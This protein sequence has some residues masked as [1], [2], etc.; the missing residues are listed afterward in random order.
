[1]IATSPNGTAARV[2]YID[3]LTDDGTRPLEEWV[4]L[5]PIGHGTSDADG[6]DEDL[7][8]ELQGGE[9]D[10][11][12]LMRHGL[13][14]RL[15]P[16]FE[17]KYRLRPLP[18][19][20]PV[21]ADLEPGTLVEVR[22]NDG[23]WQAEIIRAD[24]HRYLCRFPGENDQDRVPRRDMRTALCWRLGNTQSAGAAPADNGI[25]RAHIFDRM[26]Q[27]YLA[28]TG[29][30]MPGGLVS[31]SP[32][33]QS[34][35]LRLN[36]DSCAVCHR[37]GQLLCC[38]GC[39][40]AVHYSCAGET[41]GSLPDGEYFC[42]EC[43]AIAPCSR[44][45]GPTPQLDQ[46]VGTSCGSWMY[47]GADSAGKRHWVLRGSIVV[48]L[49]P[50][51]PRRSRG[52]TDALYPTSVA[53]YHG[54]QLLTQLM[55]GLRSS[56]GELDGALANN[57]ASALSNRAVA[58]RSDVAGA[59][60]A[61]DA[62]M[63]DVD[64]GAA[65]KLAFDHEPLN[66]AGRTE[67]R[68]Y[69]NKY[70]DAPVLGD[71]VTLTAP[72]GT[73][74]APAR[75][76]RFAW[77]TPI[78]GMK[79]PAAHGDNT[80]ACIAARCVLLERV[81]FSL[82][83]GPWR[84][85][86]AAQ[87]QE[88]MEGV[89][90]ASEPAQLASKLLQLE[91]SLRSVVFHGT[92]SGAAL[93]WRT[94]TESARHGVLDDSWP[95]PP[96][97]LGRAFGESH[98][99]PAQPARL[100]VEQARRLGRVG[101]SLLCADATYSSRGRVTRHWASRTVRSAWVAATQGCRTAS[102]L[103]LQLR[104]LDLQ[105]RW[106]A[107]ARP[108]ARESAAD[109][110]AAMGM[111]AA[112]VPQPEVK[113]KRFMMN[114]A[115]T[116]T[117]ANTVMPSAW[118]SASAAGTY[119]TEYLVGPEGNPE[120]VW[121]PDTSAPLW[122]IRCYE[123]AQRTGIDPTNA[124]A[125]RA[126]SRR[127][128]S[129]EELLRIGPGGHVE[130]FWLETGQWYSASLLAIVRGSGMRLQYDVTGDIEDFGAQSMAAMV[131][132]DCIAVRAAGRAGGAMPRGAAATGA[133]AVGRGGGRERG[134]DRGNKY[135]QE[136]DEDALPNP[137]KA[138]ERVLLEG[139]VLDWCGK[140]V[141]SWRMSKR[142]IAGML[143]D[144]VLAAAEAALA[145]GEK[146]P[147]R[148]ASV[149]TA[150]KTLPKRMRLVT[151][152]GAGGGGGRGSDTEDDDTYFQ[153]MAAAGKQE[154]AGGKQRGGG[155][156]KPARVR[157]PKP[158]P[159]VYSLD[160]DDRRRALAV[161]QA[162]RQ[163]RGT[164]G[165]AMGAKF[166]HVP[167]RK[168]SPEYHKVVKYP[169]DLNSIAAFLQQKE[170]YRTPW[171]FA[172]AVE[173]LLTNTQ[174]YHPVGSAMHADADR[175]RSLFHT[176]HR[177]NFGQHVEMPPPMALTLG[178]TGEEPP[179]LPKEADEEAAVPPDGAGLVNTAAGNEQIGARLRLWWPEDAAW[180]ACRVLRTRKRPD[181]SLQH[182]VR[183]ED[184]QVEDWVSLHEERWEQ[185]EPPSQ[186]AAGIAADGTPAMPA[187][188]SGGKK[189][190]VPAEPEEGD[191]RPPLLGDGH[192]VIGLPVSIQ[193]HDGLFYDGVVSGYEPYSEQHE[194]TYTDGSI[195]MLYLTRG[196]KQL[197]RWP[198]GLPPPLEDA[199][200]E[201]L[202]VMRN[203]KDRYGV[204]LALPFER[205]PSKEELPTYYEVISYPMDFK[206]IDEKLASGAYK[207]VDQFVSDV[208]VM[209][210]NCYVFNGPEHPYTHSSRRLRDAFTRYA[211]RGGELI[212][213]SGKVTPAPKKSK[214]KTEGG[215]AAGGVK[216]QREEDE[217]PQQ[218]QQQAAA[219]AAVGTVPD[220]GGDGLPAPKKLF[221]MAPATA[222][223]PAA[224]NGGAAAAAVAVAPPMAF[225]GLKIKF[226]FG[227]GGGGGGAEGG[228]AA[229]R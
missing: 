17:R 78:A 215:A 134:G 2:R 65:A 102:G 123:E 142:K 99:A 120:G 122:A 167:T 63:M 181:G 84:T 54:T 77:P 182:R 81:L 131:A 46:L 111:P 151:T 197:V 83:D 118:S 1:V 67:A 98:P 50:M 205:L 115:A 222:A 106:D 3:L 146:M 225:G 51:V 55:H 23:W 199:C 187:S 60:A 34:R 92:A 176:V 110:L 24:G 117:A 69:L 211:G 20:L 41:K 100:P 76:R 138:M 21:P 183:Y 47:V 195:E 7:D 221:V 49:D 196:T 139:L 93:G 190:G 27:W 96:I 202:T 130:V 213:G 37:P 25:Q 44:P 154:D 223:Q 57:L 56:G 141:S 61:S 114:T 210:D 175:M 121:M 201:S 28:D 103:A 5:E 108:N 71:K 11:D 126:V 105:I 48:R 136:I 79:S 216:R 33:Q 94:C 104:L 191:E 4:S 147:M 148:P 166:A 9:G 6:Q 91:R 64:G 68:L 161:L 35:D 42:P 156:S 170:T 172:Y 16:G 179:D 160:K 189:R 85:N 59:T 218:Q 150:E 193:W 32:P 164:D 39:P 227:G 88:W 168:E 18:P 140:D 125:A 204:Q 113:H 158:E 74:D 143:P 144:G 180:Y 228:D 70:R 157:A 119:R 186:D 95:P 124:L 171:D 82:C 45:G 206:C 75:S 12:A 31:V 173:L 229:P 212:G 101:G 159:L 58:P 178:I 200:R 38:D 163:A 107:L 112:R 177:M 174:L 86:G 224:D 128:L 10:D 208:L 226:K 116:P 72:S 137:S 153:R 15:R 14:A 89:T 8:D 29:A 145:A 184:D 26:G 214:V 152:P 192:C 198:R 30:P 149:A 203:V 80:L 219:A 129:V 97:P 220:H 194:V 162:L 209:W 36:L 13:P 155:T 109:Q 62:T 19:L 43:N 73:S 66:A 22:L 52:W 165:S 127:A 133:A 207:D 217:P 169:I 90:S 135:V 185:L 188:K 87:R 53:L 132:A 40:L